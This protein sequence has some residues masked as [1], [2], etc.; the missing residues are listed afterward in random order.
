MKIIITE[1]QYKKLTLQRRL[2]D[3]MDEGPM[4]VDYADEFYGD[5][6]FCR[7]YP[8]LEVY[9]DGM[10]QDIIHQYGNISD[11]G[12]EG[13]WD[14]IYDVVGF[15]NFINMLLEEHGDKIIRFYKEKTKDC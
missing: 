4:I 13:V 8:T 6:D 10:V 3:I 7:H 5:T 2:A 1:S 9:V 14:F 11:S 15:K 12:V